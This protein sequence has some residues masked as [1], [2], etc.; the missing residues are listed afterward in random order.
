MRLT[1]LI[2]ASIITSFLS[3]IHRLL[4]GNYNQAA[5]LCGSAIIL[6]CSLWL[7]KK[8]HL[9]YATSLFLLVLTSTIGYFM[10]QKQGLRDEVIM[11]FPIVLLSA[12]LLGNNRLF[13]AFFMIILFLL[14]AN[15]IVNEIGL[16]TNEIAPITLND[17]V[18]SITIFSLMA[19]CIWLTATDLQ[20]L[21]VQL[22]R[23]NQ[24]VQK[25]KAEIEKLANLDFLT[26]LP[27]RMHAEACF[28]KALSKTMSNDTNVGV[29]FLDLDNFK[30]VNDG[31]G[32]QAGDMLL[33]ALSRRIEKALG[34]KDVVCRFGGD[35]FLIILGEVNSLE[36]TLELAADLQLNISRPV[37][38]NDN[39]IETTSTAGVVL[40]PLQ[41]DD[42]QQV[43]RYADIAMY[44]CKKSSK[45]SVTAFTESMNDAVLARAELIKDIEKAIERHEFELYYQPKIDIR[46]KKISSAEALIRWNHP[47]KG[48]IS[49][50][51]F[52]PVAETSGQIIQIGNWV[53]E[54]ACKQCKL[55]IDM[56]Y[57]KLVI[58]INLSPVQFQR[59]NVERQLSTAISCS[60]V[61][62]TALE[63]ELTESLFI[64]DS[65]KL[66]KTLNSIREMGINLS[67]DD[68]G[69]GYS[70]LEY[71]KRFDVGTIKID[72]SFISKLAEDEQDY[73]IVCAII[74]MASKLDLK[75]VA[76]GVEVESIVGI[77]STLECQDGQ[78]Y[79]WSK[80]LPVKKFTTYLGKYYNAPCNP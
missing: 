59:S 27:N 31:L 48:M 80:P 66:R 9:Q 22:F 64:N 67:I 73:A 23:E 40:S 63:V 72:K 69:T 57:D 1:Q 55:W 28:Y 5:I 10:F 42:F 33:C 16:Y 29:I 76:E 3:A 20:R 71:L 41:T 37:F 32:H 36:Q 21:V 18:V 60:G 39:H 34:P 11:A 44:E 65:E 70:N 24:R 75:V 47:T 49:P 50:D 77:L 54:E 8:H 19:F 2:W 79:F 15:S 58:A 45:G 53:I 56:G 61:P 4:I 14:L 68:F 25:S 7:I 43:I 62:P 35:E 17:G 52:I 74:E 46:S 78:G 26:K 6:V 38:I 30:A 12:A 13:I 51:D